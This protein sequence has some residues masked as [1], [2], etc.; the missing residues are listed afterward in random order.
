MKFINET[1]LKDMNATLFN[2]YGKQGLVDKIN[3]LE[4]RL[5]ALETKKRPRKVPVD[6]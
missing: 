4:K 1:V 5:Q 6:A 2:A 3:E